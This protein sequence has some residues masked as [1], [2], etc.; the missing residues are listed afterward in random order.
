M[1]NPMSQSKIEPAT[2]RLVLHCPKSCVG[3]IGSQ[4]KTFATIKI[5]FDLRT[6]QQ[7]HLQWHQ[8]NS[9]DRQ[10]LRN[11]DFLLQIFVRGAR[12]SFGSWAYRLISLCIHRQWLILCNSISTQQIMRLNSEK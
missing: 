3:D 12:L 2:F 9:A 6:V 11:T 1:K 10:L 5:H 4:L 7:P 8:S